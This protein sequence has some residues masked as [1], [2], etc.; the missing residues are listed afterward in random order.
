MAGGN[1]VSVSVGAGNTITV[2]VAGST[3]TTPTITNGGTATVTVTSVG[4]RGPQG[5]VGPATTLTIGTVTTGAAGSNASATI[6]GT[7]PSQTLSLT[8][9]RGDTGAA[10]SLTIGTVETGAAGSTASATITGTAPNQALNLTIPRG[11]SGTAG[12]SWQPVP[13]SPS[14]SGTAGQIA[15]DD[16]FFYVRSADGW[17]RVAIATWAPLGAPTSV[18]ATAGN[19]QATVSWTAP[20]DNGGYAITDYAVQFSSNGGTTWTTFADGTSTTTSATVAGLTNGT[21]YVFRVAAINS[22]GTGPYSAATSSVTPGVPTD[23]NF[24]NV[25][26]LLH[27]NGNG[28]TFVDSSP[29]PKTVTANG[30]A[31]QSTAQSKF[32]GKSAYFDGIFDKLTIPNN[33]AFHFGSGDYTVEAWLYVP[34]I[35]TQGGGGF[36]SHAQNM[37]GFENRQFSFSVNSTG[38]ALQFSTNGVS[39]QSITFS[40]SLPSNQWIHV[41]FA[42]ASGTLRAFV[43]GTQI[44]TSQSNNATYFTSPAPICVGASGQFVAQGE[45]YLDFEG[46]IDEL[47]ITKG[48]ARYTAN[49]TPPTA[50]F[51]DA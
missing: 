31:T 10:N 41:A 1:E 48:V 13:M 37:S 51:P 30:N 15:Y 4:D 46:Y 26:L 25:S 3:G 44:G 32:G 39:Y 11:D 24:A 47:R 45:E 18:A 9:P 34:Q 5:D 40:T 16:S 42:R 35:N 43:D 14:A 22:A 29:T 2:A 6:T 36:F 12:V 38:L 33:S 50:P 49:F 19:A 23:P 28:S 20:V 27:M 7:A 17:R 21:V 8:I